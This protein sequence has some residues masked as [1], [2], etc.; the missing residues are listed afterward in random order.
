[1]GHIRAGRVARGPLMGSRLILKAYPP[2]LL[3]RIDPIAAEFDLNG[4]ADNEV[5]THE[6]LQ[7]CSTRFSPLLQDRECICYCQGAYLNA[8]CQATAGQPLIVVV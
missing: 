6:R 2:P 5:H 8:M 1:V 3:T 4:I 7:V